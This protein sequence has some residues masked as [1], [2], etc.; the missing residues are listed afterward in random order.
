[1]LRLE[2]V[3][4]TRGPS[5]PA[6]EPLVAR[7]ALDRLELD[8][9]SLDPGGFRQRD[10]SRAPL[11]PALRL[12]TGQGFSAAAEARAFKQ[13]PRL[14]VRRS[15][16]GALL[17]DDDYS[18]EVTDSIVD[19]GTGPTD[20]AGP[21]AIG[22]AADPVNGWSAPLTVSGATF[23]GP[24]RVAHV[25]GT[26]GIWTQRLEARDDQHGCISLSYLAGVADRLPQNV[27]CVRGT[28]A[29]LR[30]TSIAFGDPAYGQL[31]R[32]TDIRIRERGPGDD[33]M[34]AFGFQ[35][36]AHKW[37]NVRIRYREFMPLGIRPLLI[38]VT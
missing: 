4:V 5:F 9:A 7:A 15:I 28:D 13:T 34:G 3:L 26:G 1:M 17:V 20:P 22:A 6:G 2:G 25:E 8:G 24:V 14:V 10:G 29:D 23:L 27:E 38:P 33:E 12:R 35:R 37:R 18:L 16:V 30:F 19:A 36:E 32:T 21:P 11:L 31:A